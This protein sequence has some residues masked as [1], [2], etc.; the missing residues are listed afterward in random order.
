ML[1]LGPTIIH[2]CISVIEGLVARG[3]LIVGSSV[4]M[5]PVSYLPEINEVI[6]RLVVVKF[7]I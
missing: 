4:N 7:V 6:M 2:I 1:V 5:E 3:S